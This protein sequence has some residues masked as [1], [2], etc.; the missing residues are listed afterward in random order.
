ML[1]LCLTAF[2][3]TEHEFYCTD[4]VKYV[5]F[6]VTFMAATLRQCIPLSLLLLLLLL[7]FNCDTAIYPFL[8]GREIQLAATELRL[9]TDF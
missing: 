4:H 6:S 2:H 1:N 7:L 8:G 9:I 3:N 5:D